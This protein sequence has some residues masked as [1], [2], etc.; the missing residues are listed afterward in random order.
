MA[1]PSWSLTTSRTRRGGWTPT[2]SLLGHLGPF[3]GGWGVAGKGGGDDPGCLGPSWEGGR[4][5]RVPG[6]LAWVPTLDTWVLF[7]DPWASS[8]LPECPPG[9]LGASPVRLGAHPGRLGSLYQTPGSPFCSLRLHN[10]RA[11][12][13][14]ETLTRAPCVRPSCSLMR[15]TRARRLCKMLLQN[16]YVLSR[17]TLVL[18]CSLVQDPHTGPSCKTLVQDPHTLSCETFM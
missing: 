11:R 7:P 14:C 13:S 8:W 17:K 16:P 15:D 3:W 18:F 1:S 6:A 12:P 2:R 10:P 4:A 9:R 5:I